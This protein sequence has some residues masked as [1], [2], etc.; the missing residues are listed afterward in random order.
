MRVEQRRAHRGYRRLPVR[1]HDVDRGE[2]MLRHPERGD[3]PA[4]AVEPEA[5]PDRLERGEVGLRIGVAP[6]HDYR[7]S[8]SSSLRKRSSLRRSA[9]T[10]SAGAFVTKTSFA[11]LPSAR[12]IS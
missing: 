10:T 4:D 1:P 12:A 8:S 5:P 6:R 2:A 11:S 9:S 3:E 7:P